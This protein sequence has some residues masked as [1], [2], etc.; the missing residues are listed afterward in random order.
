MLRVSKNF[1]HFFGN[2]KEGILQSVQHDQLILFI[3][4]YNTFMLAWEFD[5]H[6]DRDCL[7]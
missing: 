3:S 6:I 5:E 2:Q 7:D 1:M 4:L